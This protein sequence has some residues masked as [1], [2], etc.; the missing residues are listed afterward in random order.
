M[1]L[2]LCA[3]N[4]LSEEIVTGDA[5]VTAD[6]EATGYEAWHVANAR[7]YLGDRWQPTT[8]NANHY[9]QRTFALPRAFDFV[10]IDR[11][12]NH[13]G[14]P[15]SLTHSGDGFTT[16][17]TPWSLTIPTVPGGAP[18]GAVGCVTDEGAWL[19]T[20]PTE[21]ARGIRLNSLAMGA[22]LVPQ[23]TGVWIG[24]SWQP[25][26]GVVEEH[27]DDERWRVQTRSSLSAAGWRGRTRPSK[28]RAGTL[29]LYLTT[30]QDVDMLRYHI[31]LM[32]AGHPAWLVFD[33]DNGGRFA[34]LIWLP[35]D[36][37]LDL[38]QKFTLPERRRF[39]IPFVEEQPSLV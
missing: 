5:A 25:T 1:L 9:V 22:G 26:V 19:K 21:I 39:E 14:Y 16:I 3:E 13:R 24:K 11:E 7:R 4:L 20:F 31:G 35:D 27:A 10:A 37:D 15:Y 2:L 33:R 18:A 36:V 17:S 29:V 23:L 34:R 6:Q 38:G 12:S 32:M 30:V 8:A 28:A